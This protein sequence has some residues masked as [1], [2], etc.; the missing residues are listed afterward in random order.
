VIAAP[1]KS[2]RP[3]LRALGELYARLYLGLYYEVMG[4][5]SKSVSWLKKSVEVA[6]V[7][8]YMGD[9]A[10]VHLQLRTPSK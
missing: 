4:D 6:Q 8:G 5:S 1:G 9:V 7:G 2:P 10:R 3:E